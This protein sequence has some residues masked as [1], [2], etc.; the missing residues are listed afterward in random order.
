VQKFG[1][2]GFEL[3]WGSF[4]TG[5]GQF[6]APDSIAIDSAGQVY[7][8]DNGTRRIQVFDTDGVFVS[9][10]ADGAIPPSGRA[11]KG[12]IGATRGLYIDQDDNLY[13]TDGS[14][15]CSSFS[16]FDS[17]QNFVTRI[18]D[19]TTL[20]IGGGSFVSRIYGI[21]VSPA[22]VVY[23]GCS[24]DDGGSDQKIQVFSPIAPYIQTEHYA[25]TPAPVSLGTPDGG[26]AIPALDGLSREVVT[27]SLLAAQII[28]DMR[29][30]I[31]ALAPYF[32]SSVTKRVFN[33]D[34]LSTDNLYRLAVDTTHYGDTGTQYNWHRTKEQMY[35]KFPV[36]RD[37]G[38]I[39]DCVTLLEASNLV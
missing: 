20:P 2:G 19:G 29:E 22:G 8:T 26:V 9:K 23:V 10:F 39:E 31:E 35:D 14:L 3:K 27:G 37:I 16:V 33:W 36:A 17:N 38:E 4:G 30:A 18:G 11:N 32:I 5:N 13:V 15:N 7:V 21:A 34:D 24:G 6:Q 1:S 28:E 12:T 25:Y